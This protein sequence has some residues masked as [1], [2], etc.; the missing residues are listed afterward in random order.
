MKNINSYGY[1]VFSKNEEVLNELIEIQKD[2]RNTINWIN[3][4]KGDIYY[5]NNCLEYYIIYI[6]NINKSLELSKD[7]KDLL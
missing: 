7:I 1:T 6:D 2:E 5:S 4:E 3:F